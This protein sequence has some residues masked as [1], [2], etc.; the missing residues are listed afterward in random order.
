MVLVVGTVIASVAGKCCNDINCGD[1]DDNVNSY[2]EAV[3]L[4]YEHGL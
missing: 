2:D 3:R 1:C 4:I